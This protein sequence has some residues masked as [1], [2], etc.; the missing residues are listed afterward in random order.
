MHGKDD[1]LDARRVL[2]DLR[3]QIKAGAILERDIDD[4]DI[5]P[6]LVDGIQAALAALGL[7][8]DH[9]VGLLIDHIRQPLAHERMVIDE[10]DAAAGAGG[11]AFGDRGHG[12]IRRPFPPERNR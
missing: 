1:D 7:A 10:E 9:E 2:L 6:L 4:G 11:R 5:G 12:F 3:D 8:A